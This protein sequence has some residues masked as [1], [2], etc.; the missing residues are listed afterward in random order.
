MFAV[1]V[2]SAYVLTFYLGIGPLGV[3]IAMG[4]D[5]FVRGIC[6]F[7][8]WKSGKWQKKAVI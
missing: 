3:W 8:R 4:L 5:F 2:S 1:R 6:Y 7:A